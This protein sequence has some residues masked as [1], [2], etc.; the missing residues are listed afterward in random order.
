VREM[1]A[2]RIGDIAAEKG[3]ALHE[4]VPQR[5]RLEAAFMQLTQDS[6]EYTGEAVRS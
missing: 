4:L 6:V 2:P 1:P 5:A 3:L